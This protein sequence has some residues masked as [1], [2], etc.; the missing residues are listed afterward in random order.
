MR[1][2]K[3]LLIFLSVCIILVAILWISPTL[4][5][6]YASLFVSKLKGTLTVVQR[7]SLSNLITALSVSHLWR[8]FLNTIV[9]S[10]STVTLVVCFASGAA[11]AFSRLRFQGRMIIYTAILLTLM[12]PQAS[13]AIPLFEINKYLHLFNNYLGL[14]LPYSALNIPFCLVILKG[15]F[16]A[17]PKDI[18]EAAIVDG[19]S[20]FRI[21]VQ[22][23]IP[24]SLSSVSIVVIWTLMQAWNEFVLALLFMTSPSMKTLSL[25]PMVFEGQYGGQEGALLAFLMITSIPIVITYLLLQKYFERGLTSGA[26]K[27]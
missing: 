20:M 1:I 10:F 14:I 16:D 19:A 17:F 18:E 22:I 21:F 5:S 15:F 11:F 25:A 26:V 12:L 3:R 8:Y 7:F 9:I 4:Q 27:G 24:N 6:I 13:L 23:L 2:S